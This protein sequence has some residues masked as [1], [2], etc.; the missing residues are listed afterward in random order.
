MVLLI[1]PGY[2]FIVDLIKRLQ[3]KIVSFSLVICDALCM[4]IKVLWHKLAPNV[5]HVHRESSLWQVIEIFIIQPLE[6]EAQGW[7]LKMFQLGKCSLGVW[8]EQLESKTGFWGNE[9][10]STS[11][12]RIVDCGHICQSTDAEKLVLMYSRIGMSMDSILGYEGLW[13]S[14][15][16]HTQVQKN[17]V[18]IARWGEAH[19]VN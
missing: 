3:S 10:R 18:L 12:W 6:V 19:T 9:Y 13:Y 7:S 11:Q 17:I 5:G 1:P 15:W 8:P 2:Q 4:D 16:E 14:K